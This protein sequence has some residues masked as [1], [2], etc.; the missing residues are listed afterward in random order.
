MNGRE[1][2]FLLLTSHLGD[3]QRRPLSQAQFRTLAQRVREMEV[4]EEQRDLKASDL[5]ELGFGREMAERIICLLAEEDVLEH[6]LRR[7]HQAGCVPLTWAS[8]AYPKVVRQRLGEDAPGCLWAKGNLE[9]LS[10]PMISLVGSR[11]IAQENRNFARELG[12]QAAQQGFVLV[13]GNA[14]GAD[15]TAQQACISAGGTVISVVADELERCPLQE[16]VL[17][18]SEDVFDGAFS[19]QRALSRNRIIHC[20]GSRVFVAQCRLQYGGTWDGTV[21]NLRQEWSPVFCYLD[22]SE[23]MEMLLQMGAD[24][25]E[26][27]DLRNIHALRTPYLGLFDQ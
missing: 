9:L 4:P 26:L 16:N 20:L 23:A 6:Y 27:E 1:R 21:K 13:S 15:R 8:D 2:G 3:S 14:R 24:G 22:G 25:V 11:D 17:Y 19:A 18:L 12:R 5:I 7:G 10:S